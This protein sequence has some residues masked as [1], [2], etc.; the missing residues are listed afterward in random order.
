MHEMQ[1]ADLFY[2]LHLAASSAVCRDTISK[3]IAPCRPVCPQTLRQA[4]CCLT[5][6]LWRPTS[7]FLKLLRTMS[8][9]TPTAWRHT[10][11]ARMQGPGEKPPAQCVFGPLQGFKHRA[12]QLHKACGIVNTHHIHWSF[13]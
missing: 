12:P 5:L 3:R 8:G 7:L 13:G 9:S 10:T 1:L 6:S 2:P 11:T 4:W